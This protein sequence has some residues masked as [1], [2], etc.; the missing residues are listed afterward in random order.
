MRHRGLA[1]L[2]GTLLIA[3]FAPAAAGAYTGVG[4]AP[5]DGGPSS[6]G[7]ALRADDRPRA[8]RP[9]EPC[10]AGLARRG[11][12]RRSLLP[13]RG[14]R[15][16]RRPATTTSPSPTTRRRTAWMPSTRSRAVTS[17]TLSRFDLDLQQLD[18]SAVTVQR[19]AGDL[20]PRRAG[21]A[22]HAEEEA[23][24]QGAYLRRQRSAT[25]ASRRRSSARRSSSARPT[26]S[27][28]PTTEP[29]RATSPTLPRPGSR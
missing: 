9:G 27:S 26:G 23:G 8:E 22:D 25:A 12:H 17:Q 3:A 4:T 15:R 21:A 16:L 29:S 2:A 1:A 6:D 19:Q 7:R 10:G 28:T 18:V 13:A 11:R 24:R 14:Q 20:H 5:G